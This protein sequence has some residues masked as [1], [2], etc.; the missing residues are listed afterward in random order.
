MQPEHDG[1]EPRERPGDGG[2]SEQSRPQRHESAFGA[3]YARQRQ[4]QHGQPQQTQSPHSASPRGPSPR[5]RPQYAPPPYALPPYVAPHYAAAFDGRDAPLIHPA[6][7]QASTVT[8][9]GVPVYRSPGVGV[10]PQPS[11]GLSITAL[12]LGLCS[13]VFAW[14]FVV[15]PII[16]LVFGFLAL[17]REPGSKA[18]AI[19]GLVTSGLGLVW[20]L[21]LYL[22]PLIAFLG[23]ILFA[24]ASP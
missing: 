5:S 2:V 21:L 7:A 17:R 8:P 23:A 10:M 14:I 19:V 6:A 15:V 4:P 3:D 12:V 22:L 9:Y 1:F 16:G 20:V 24:S 11:R 13:V 18:M